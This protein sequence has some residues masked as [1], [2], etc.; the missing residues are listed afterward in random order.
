MPGL[1]AVPVNP[2]SAQSL[3]PG[4]CLFLA[5]TIME[6]GLWAVGIMAKGS[7]VGTG[8]GRSELIFWLVFLG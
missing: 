5:A 1:G 7:V 6:S 4:H 2:R 3:C 8:K